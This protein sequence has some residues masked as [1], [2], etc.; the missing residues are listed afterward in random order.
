MTT[1]LWWQTVAAVL[2]GVL[3]AL[4]TRYVFI[5]SIT[6]LTLF[7]LGLLVAWAMDPFLDALERKGWTRV[8]AVW[9]VTL[10]FL[11]VIATIGILVI[12]GIVSQVQDAANHWRDYS[13]TAQTTYSYWRTQLEDYAQRHLPNV[14]VM[15]F[16]DAK[17]QQ[18]S[19]WLTDHLPAVLQWL[20]QTLISSFSLIALFGLLLII[21]FHFMNV[22]KPLRRSV[23]EMLPE[24]TDTEMEHLGTQINEM[25]GQYLRGIVLVSF[26]VGVSATFILYV[27]SLFFGTKY[28]LIIGVITGVTYMI[29][30][31]GPLISA[32][33][34]GFFG[35]VTAAND[36]WIACFTAVAGMYLVNQVFD[37]AITPRIVG[38][39][40]G[41]HPLVVLFS[42]F[43]G[44]SLL[45]IPGMIIAT[46]LAGCIKI[47]LARWLPFKKMDN[48]MP[49][50]KRTLE[51]DL[52]GTVALLTRQAARLGGDIERGWMHTIHPK[53]HHSGQPSASRPGE[54]SDQTEIESAPDT[55]VTDSEA[56]Q[57]DKDTNGDNA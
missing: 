56:P 25:L 40:V 44:V 36:P 8:V 22:I 30:Y 53:Q 21:S 50:T 4:V 26:L 20:S 19:Q 38:Q 14:E 15:P 24:S 46:P 39:R 35:Y 52:P 31:I 48:S 17:V 57:P 6:I 12:P 18:S 27:L 13:D 37:V 9:G 28:A 1:R 43:M 33:T 5:K 49:C 51:L 16:L 3:L 2:V 10:G 41:L 11:V 55:S 34:A 32:V 54:P 7:A 29:P 45:G 47:I 23:L 42:V